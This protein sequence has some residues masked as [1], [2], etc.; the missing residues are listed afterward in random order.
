MLAEEVSRGAAFGDLDN[1]GDTDIVVAN[2]RGSPRLYRNNAEPAPWLGIELA[3]TPGLPTVGSLVWL[4]GA[5]C[6]KRRVATDGSYASANANRL[7]L[8]I[9]PDASPRHVHVRW[10][11]GEEQRFGPL[12]AGRYHTLQR[13]SDGPNE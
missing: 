10:P 9:G 11:D 7:R 5:R 12:A 1:D 2:T 6:P 4:D 3:A 13:R 8:P